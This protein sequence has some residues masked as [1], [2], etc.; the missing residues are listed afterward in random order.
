MVRHPDP[1]GRI[2]AYVGSEP[3][4][5]IWTYLSLRARRVRSICTNTSAEPA[6]RRLDYDEADLVGKSKDPPARTRAHLQL[7]G[8]VYESGGVI[9]PYASSSL[10]CRQRPCRRRTVPIADVDETG[11]AP[12]LLSA[13]CFT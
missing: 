3:P 6:L 9:R 7:G 4:G 1:Q 8:G 5:G 11:S 10:R 13:S 2:V 12:L